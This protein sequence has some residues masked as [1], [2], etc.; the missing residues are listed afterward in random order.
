MGFFLVILVIVVIG[1]AVAQGVSQAKAVE[2]SRKAYHTSLAALAAQ[3]GIARLRQD[4]LALGRAYSN[5][6]RDKKG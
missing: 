1:L 3:P 6:T 4:T 5:L 2:N